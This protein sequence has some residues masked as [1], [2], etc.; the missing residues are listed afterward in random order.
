MAKINEIKAKAAMVE[1]RYGNTLGASK[2]TKPPPK[3][4]IKFRP[5]GGLKPSGGKLS[6]TVKF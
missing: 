5:T 1:A 4:K 6:V 2:G 3:P